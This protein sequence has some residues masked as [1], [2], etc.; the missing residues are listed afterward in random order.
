MTVQYV[1]DTNVLI[2][3]IKGYYSHE[4]CPG[5][6]EFLIHGF[7]SNVIFSI[8]RVY[9]ELT[10]KDQKDWVAE[11]AKANKKFFQDCDDDV[12]NHVARI[13]S[14]SYVKRFKQ[15]Q[16]AAFHDVADPWLI[17]YA[18]KHGM[19]VVTLE[20][21]K[22]AQSKIKI[23]SICEE[24]GVPVINTFQMLEKLKARFVQN[25]RSPSFPPPYSHPQLKF[26]DEP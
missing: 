6:W 9:G 20:G 16:I 18:K 4:I 24:L 7:E 8:D 1:L 22:D 3:A 14:I 2:Q 12:G 23:P 19:T 5:F 26:E 25:G 17:G 11:W 10:E 21:T 15:S 13:C